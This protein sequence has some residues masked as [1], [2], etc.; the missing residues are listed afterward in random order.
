MQAW[1]AL[2]FWWSMME[3]SLA[4]VDNG[5]VVSTAG[6][7]ASVPWWSF[8]K[9]IIAAGALALV[10]DGRLVLDEALPKRRYTLRQLLQHRAGVANYGDLAAYHEAVARGDNPWPL[11]VLLER[12]EADRLR[13][14]PGNGWSY[15]NIGYLFVRQLIEATC[16]EPLGEAL[17]QLVLQPLGIEG[18]RIALAPSDLAGVIM[19]NAHQYH[20]GWVY[21]GLIVGP[22]DQA[23]LLLSRL[24]T[25]HLLP[26]DLI[27]QMQIGEVLDV[28]V[29][30]R[31]WMEPIYGLGLMTGSSTKGLHIAGH[32]GAG[33]GSAIAVYH[34]KD[35]K[36][37]V[38]AAAFSAGDD[39]ALVETAAFA[40]LEDT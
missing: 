23:A 32:T 34:T 18:A 12:T 21:H 4:V 35:G 40:A 22:L 10:R 38:T 33:P 31:P 17:G 14:E 28:P 25:G 3:I 11:S 19:G 36:R 39:Q 26:N 16:N 1:L 6:V 9:T 5:T 8:T 15:S 30:G 37:P 24:L 2:D 13:F 27:D 29:A 20:P 7:T